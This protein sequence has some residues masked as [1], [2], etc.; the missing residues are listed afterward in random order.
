MP[1]ILFDVL[2]P[3]EPAA[4]LLHSFEG[5]V[6]KLIAANKLT[7]GSVALDPH[8]PLVDGVE[9][10]LR[11]SYRDEHE[12]ADLDNSSV[13]RYIINVEGATGSINQLA[14]VLSRFMTPQANLPADAVLL[15]NQSSLEIPA[16]YPWAVEIRR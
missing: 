11:Q 3:A 7:G 15:E 8:P 14:M 9:E 12:D 4:Q 2:L 10:A 16:I 1:A 5:A 6:N 13:V